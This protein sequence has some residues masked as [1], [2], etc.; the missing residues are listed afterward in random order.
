LDA[1]RRLNAATRDFALAEAM[2][3][4]E[5]GIYAA[6]FPKG[7]VLIDTEDGSIVFRHERDTHPALKSPSPRSVWTKAMTL[8]SSARG[9][10]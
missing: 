5:D 6:S 8:R 10:L 2:V 1:G 9:Q 4:W 7:F 3:L